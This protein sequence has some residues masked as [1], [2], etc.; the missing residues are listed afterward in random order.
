MVILKNDESSHLGMLLL[1]GIIRLDKQDKSGGA[2]FIG[3][4]FDVVSQRKQMNF[5][6]L[7]DRVFKTSWELKLR[8]HKNKDIV[9]LVTEPVA[10]FSRWE[11]TQSSLPYTKVDPAH[12]RFDVPVAKD[13]EVVLTYT[14]RVTN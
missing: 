6:R 7:S 14:A 11:I 8:N 2:Q 10:G 3:E 5:Q 1:E 9:V 4:A 12:I 13:G